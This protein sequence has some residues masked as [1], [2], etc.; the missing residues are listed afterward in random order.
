MA[1]T[2]RR[3]LCFD[4]VKDNIKDPIIN[5]SRGSTKT[6]I[7]KN[8]GLVRTL[9]VNVPAAFDDACGR[10]EL[11]KAGSKN[12]LAY[13]DDPKNSSVWNVTS[14][15]AL[16]SYGYL[17]GVGPITRFIFSTGGYH[18]QRPG[19]LTNG[20]LYCLSFWA[21]KDTTAAVSVQNWGG[22]SWSA[23][24]ALTDTWT[25][26]SVVMT[27]DGNAGNSSCG[28]GGATTAGQPFLVAGFQ[29]EAGSSATAYEPNPVVI[30]PGLLIEGAATNY[31]QRSVPDGSWSSATG[32]TTAGAYLTAPDGTATA[33][34][35]QYDGSGEAGSYRYYCSPQ[36]GSAG[37]KRVLS[38]WL[39]SVSGATTLRLSDNQG[40]Y[41]VV[42]LTTSW[43]RFYL[44]G[45][46][47]NGVW[48]VLIYSDTLD[49]A[50]FS[51]GVWGAQQ[52]AGT[53]PS[54][55]IPTSGAAATRAADSATVDVSKIWNSS[56][57][58]I[59][60]E[61]D[62]GPA[63]GVYNH[64]FETT[65]SV[66]NLYRNSSSTLVAK[67]G[68]I[69][70]GTRYGRSMVAQVYAANSVKA[71]ISGESVAQAAQSVLTT[72]TIYLGSGGNGNDLLNG[73]LQRLTYLPFAMDDLTLKA[74]SEL[75]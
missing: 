10:Q 57:G 34:P 63:T 65:G 1:N 43:Q 4:F 71:S 72:T 69:S 28:F 52:E 48:Q 75:S 66:M 67:S 51:I 12:L 62:F 30:Q 58:T 15:V 11:W 64:A 31:V 45:V 37:E 26:Y 59:I 73:T 35:V 53:F 21:K 7:D 2:N 5:F 23:P 54:S 74:S 6:I 29:L 49:N 56:E 24:I 46:G 50:P 32:V 18:Y 38:I 16:S 20:S 27:G 47:T 19:A 36:A 13:S 68:Y 40:T 44:P 9:G 3:Y 25:R 8:T 39:R 41:G 61:A 55:Y 22:N 33:M 14:A 42:K 70:F 17:N 60:C